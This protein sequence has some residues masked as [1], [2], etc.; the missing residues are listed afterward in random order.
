MNE[1]TAVS[2]NTSLDFKALHEAAQ[3]YSSSAMAFDAHVADLASQAADG[4]PWWK[5]WTR[6]KLY[7]DIRKTNS[8]L[9]LLERQFIFPEGL[10]ER[11]WFKHVVF[12][13]GRWTGY[14]GSTFPGIVESLEDKNTTNA[15]RWSDIIVERL[16]AAALSLQL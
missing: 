7:L 4:V 5:W 9:K 13:P 11:P 10:D 6:V 12:A 1:T 2:S 14:A 16:E 8:Q 15:K 3:N